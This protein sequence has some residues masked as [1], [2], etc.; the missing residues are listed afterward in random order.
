MVAVPAPEAASLADLAEKLC[1]AAQ[2]GAEGGAS[3]QSAALRAAAQAALRGG[4]R[5]PTPRQEGWRHTPLGA[6]VTTDW[7]APRPAPVDVAALDAQLGQLPEALVRLVFVDGVL[8]ARQGTGAAGV[9]VHTLTEAFAA[10]TP[11]L[12]QLGAMALHGTDVFAALNT[13]HL[14]QGATIEVAPGTV[15]DGTIQLVFV[16]TS[17]AAG[18]VLQPRVLVH[19]GRHARATVCEL[20]LAAATTPTGSWTNGVSELLVDDEAQLDYA[21][22]Q[23]QSQACIHLGAVGARVGRTARLGLYTFDVGGK[24]TRRAINVQLMAPGAEAELGHVA[25]AD[26]GQ[27]QATQAAVQHVGAHTRS[28][29]IYKAAVAAR[30][31]A[32]F[33][34]LVDIAPNAP[35]VA[36]EQVSRALLLDKN[37]QAAL[38]PQLQILTDDVKCAHGATVGELDQHALFYLMS[39]GIECAQARKLLTYAFLGDALAAAPAALQPLFARHASAWLDVDPEIAGAALGGGRK[40]GTDGAGGT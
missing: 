10:Q 18:A 23:R 7:Q 4:F 8:R 15:L 24:L 13:A 40:D 21:V 19:V 11:A 25:L 30:G 34:G 26:A 16:T 1:A 28:R 3:P 35:Q 17:A 2:P 36:A 37:A 14:Q 5:W 29:Q 27:H 22:L 32:A 38:Q 20:H 9:R 6:L 33:G 12:G 39:R 31:A